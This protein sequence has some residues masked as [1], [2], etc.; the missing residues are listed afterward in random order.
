M[1][2]KIELM[3]LYLDFIKKHTGENEHSVDK[4][5]S[6]AVK[7]IHENFKRNFKTDEIA[8]FCSV[9]PS[10][11]RLKFLRETGKTITEYRD[12]LRIKS[13]KELLSSG[14]FSV[15]EAAY[16]LGFCDVYYFTKFFTQNT[17]FSPAKY[18][19]NNVFKTF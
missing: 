18:I 2:C 12:D 10:H 16:E 4:T 3:R 17:G 14:F 19:K 15:K 5:V 1:I 7:Y 11:L 9:S 8:R 13:A 6:L